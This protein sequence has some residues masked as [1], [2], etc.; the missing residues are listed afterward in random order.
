MNIIELKWKQMNLD[1]ENIHRN[2]NLF[3]FKKK[4]NNLMN[5]I[6]CIL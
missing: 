1:R 2:G 5:C 4:Y 3:K 6:L